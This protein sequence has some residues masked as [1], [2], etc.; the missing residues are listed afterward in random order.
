MPKI[1]PRNI[2][3]PD[4]RVIAALKKMSGRDSLQQTL[5][6][7]EFGRRLT[8]SGVRDQHPDWS[9]DQVRVEIIRRMHGDAIAA[10]ATRGRST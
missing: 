10:L 7:H 1:D 6:S 4:P 9:D 3:V 5:A 2:E 8:E